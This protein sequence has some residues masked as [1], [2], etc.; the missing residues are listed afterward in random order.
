[1]ATV[2]EIAT[3][4]H[5]LTT[6]DGELWAILLPS[7]VG[8]VVPGG[9]II[10]T[11]LQSRRSAKLAEK[12]LELSGKQLDAS[13]EI[14][15]RQGDMRERE[16][17]LIAAKQVHESRA[18]FYDAWV[19]FDKV[20]KQ[21][22]RDIMAADAKDRLRKYVEASTSVDDMALRMRF[23]FG[24]DVLKVVDTAA[25]ALGNLYTAKIDYDGT[26]AEGAPSPEERATILTA[27]TQHFLDKIK[28][29]REAVR[30]YTVHGLKRD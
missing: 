16:L 7:L 22:Y 12:Q 3:V 5:K 29:V 1:M 10:V 18:D 20:M 8:A 30:A 4:A 27:A 17:E 23:Y 9:A 15:K 11:W 25:D 26:Y 24:D 6:S 21:A 14:Q 2:H 13:N 19:G 28:L